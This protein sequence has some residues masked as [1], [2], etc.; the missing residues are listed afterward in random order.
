MLHGSGARFLSTVCPDHSSWKL[1]WDNC[2]LSWCRR[3]K[4]SSMLSNRSGSSRCRETATH[5]RPQQRHRPHRRL[6]QQQALTRKCPRKTMSLA[7]TSF[8]TSSTASRGTTFGSGQKI[9]RCIYKHSTLMH[10]KFF[11]SGWYRKRNT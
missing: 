4:N 5:R 9:Q 10:A 3:S 7:R 2:K 1:K 8:Q 11:W 6:R